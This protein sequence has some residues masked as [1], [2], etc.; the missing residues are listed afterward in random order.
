MP[1]QLDDAGLVAEY[2]IIPE[3]IYT[4]AIIGAVAK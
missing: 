1:R 3:A 2:D 4:D